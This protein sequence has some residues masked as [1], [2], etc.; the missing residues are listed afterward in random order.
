MH[1]CTA[2]TYNRNSKLQNANE[3]LIKERVLWF[4]FPQP[5]KTKK[6]KQKQK[7]KQ[8]KQKQKQKQN[9]KSEKYNFDATISFL[10]DQT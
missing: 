3:A 7:Q 9:K 2:Y 6:K 10:S 1:S 8:K 4:F 5:K